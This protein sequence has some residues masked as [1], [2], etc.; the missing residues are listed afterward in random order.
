MNLSSWDDFITN[1][2]REYF[3]FET[4]RYRHPEWKSMWIDS[5][6]CDS[7]L[8]NMVCVTGSMDS[9]DDIWMQT[10]RL[11]QGI[12]VEIKDVLPGKAV[13]FLQHLHPEDARSL[14]LP[15]VELSIFQTS[16]LTPR[17]QFKGLI[18]LRMI[19]CLIPVACQAIGNKFQGRPIHLDIEDSSACITWDHAEKEYGLLLDLEEQTIAVTSSTTATIYP[20]SDY[21]EVISMLEKIM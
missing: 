16:S 19:Q 10:P 1:S 3:S 17:S 5:N 6:R 14:N 12:D 18:Y 20:M 11:L 21:G 4:I 13:C 2:I 7:E 15:K 8:L 9:F